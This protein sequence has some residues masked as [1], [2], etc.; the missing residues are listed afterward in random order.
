M[1]QGTDPT[2]ALSHFAKSQGR[3]V[4]QGLHLIS[5]GQGQ[6]IVAEGIVHVAMKAGDWVCLQVR[7]TC[8]TGSLAP[9]AEA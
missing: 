6:G 2:A 9:E 1:S 5:L 7:L 4:G 3:A 8:K